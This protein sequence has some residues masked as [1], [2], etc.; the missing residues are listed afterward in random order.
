MQYYRDSYR[1]RPSRRVTFVKR[2]SGCHCTFYESERC[3]RIAPM[4]DLCSPL[5][6]VD[7]WSEFATELWIGT[8]P[9]KPIGEPANG[10]A[11]LQRRAALL[12]YSEGPVEERLKVRPY[13]P[14]HGVEREGDID[15]VL[16]YYEQ[17]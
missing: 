5:A 11:V 9:N 16:E 2:R 10:T 3:P 1:D 6:M 4:P 14:Y 15:W 13:P 7:R 17:P 12:G 8:V